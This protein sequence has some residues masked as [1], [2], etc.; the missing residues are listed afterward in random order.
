MPRPR[1][2]RKVCCLPQNN[3]FLPAKQTSQDPIILTVDEFET[4]RLIDDQGFSQ[5]DCAKYMCIARTTAQQIY[6][7]ARKKLASALV[8]GAPILIEGG[9]YT[10]CD[11]NEPSCAC[12]GCKRHQELCMKS[13]AEIHK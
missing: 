9:D 8:Q 10:L 7:S 6:G 13:A 11:G 4:I 2:C 5:E 1:K 12:G 3:Q